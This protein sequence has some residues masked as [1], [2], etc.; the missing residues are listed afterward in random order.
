MAPIVVA[1][2]LGMG[3]IVLMEAG[4]SFLGVGVQEPT[5]SLGRMMEAGT[6]QITSAPWTSV[7]PGLVVVL[8][9]IGFSLIGDGFRDTLDKRPR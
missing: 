4:L 1:A 6:S 9:V 5:A 7:F 8:T 3:Q 2:T